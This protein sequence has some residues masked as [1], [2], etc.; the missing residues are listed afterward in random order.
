MSERIRLYKKAKR[1]GALEFTNKRYPFGSAKFWRRKGNEAIRARIARRVRKV[2]NEP[3]ILKNIFEDDENFRKIKKIVKIK[4]KFDKDED[5][6]DFS[7]GMFFDMTPIKDDELFSG[8]IHISI[9]FIDKSQQGARRNR[10]KTFSG[11]KVR[12][13]N[14]VQIF[15]YVDAVIQDYFGNFGD[16]EGYTIIRGT[17]V[18]LIKPIPK[19]VGAIKKMKVKAVKF[20]K[21][22]LNIQSNN[23]VI[24]DGENC[25]VHYIK[26]RYGEQKGFIKKVKNING[27]QNWTVEQCIKFLEDCNIPY[28][29]YLGDLKLFKYKL[30]RKSKAKI[31]RFIF[32]N[33]HIYPV[34]KKELNGLKKIKRDSYKIKQI[35]FKENLT[36]YI[37]NKMADGKVIKQYNIKYQDQKFIFERALI[38]ETLYVDDIDLVNSH[39]L[40]T[41]IMGFFPIS[42]N[43]KIY[44]PLIYIC[45][46]EKIFS[47]FNFDMEMNE[48]P[49][50]YNPDSMK[51][52]NLLCI[53]K[54]KCYSYM[55][56]SLKYI[57]VLNSQCFP[58]KYNEDE[59]FNEDYIYH[60]KKITKDS[61][62]FLSAG[63]MS[64]HR[65]K[66]FLDSVE[67]D[68]VIKPKLI[69]N[70]FSE[71]IEKMFQT[72][73]KL[74]KFII[75]VFYGICRISQYQDYTCH[76]RLVTSI[77]E[78][79]E[80]GDFRKI[81]ND[82]FQLY[83]LLE[84]KEHRLK[85]KFNLM[86]I[87]MFILDKAVNTLVEKI[88]ECKKLDPNLKVAKIKT[89]AFTMITD[90]IKYED[91]D[92]DKND[93][94]KW[95]IEPIGK[96]REQFICT[97]TLDEHE[98][99]TELDKNT[100]IDESDFILKSNAYTLPQVID[101]KDVRKYLDKNI[102]FDCLAG[103]G[104]TYECL[105]EIIPLLK[106]QNKKWLVISSQHCS[107]E[108]YYLKNHNAKV[109]QYYTFNSKVHVEFSTYDTIIIDEF[110]KLEPNQIEFIFKNCGKHCNLIFL[111]D[112]GQLLPYGYDKN[113][114]SPV[115][116]MELYKLFDYVVKLEDNWR[117]KYTKNQYQKM[118][119]L[120][121]KLTDYERK[122][123]DRI[124]DLNITVTRRTMDKINQK[125][126]KDW[127]DEFTF[128]DKKFK[129]KK[130][131]KII[132]EFFN[133]KN[134]NKLHKL[135][136]YNGI[137][138]TIKEYDKDNITI[139]DKYNKE[140]IIPMD[141]FIENFNYGYAI[142]TFRAQGRS[143]DYDKMGV[144]DYFLIRKSGRTLYTVF[145][146]IKN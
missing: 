97:D 38:D 83:T 45:E 142:T 108:E 32:T 43:Y 16:G 115:E 131:G 67:I 18:K 37:V 123:I 15:E 14:K 127:K 84:H 66:N 42:F 34:E 69:L 9:R 139:I 1:N 124:S 98:Y 57:P 111:G 130:D 8:T 30:D 65:I 107:L 17:S 93:I 125:K 51:K 114:P 144:H 7:F 21:I 135:G 95:K 99:I 24:P 22:D 87:S 73:S 134:F 117:N 27:E 39:K 132:S 5:E 126:I 13:L 25:F 143:I 82:H 106:D 101:K 136:I 29:A 76:K 20:F 79:K 140:Y 56:K 86:P 52:K 80:F 49:Y 28:Y 121:F 113:K 110:G 103:S 46:K 33:E 85:Y 58:E 2:R 10:T 61:R 71:L 137:F 72:N 4:K 90:V 92:L 36:N 118:K 55:L 96:R 53:D 40:F 3:R 91:L 89:D 102:L 70:P 112:K 23:D 41:Q 138:Y 94:S 141:L 129:L 128:G 47:S 78:A 75:N 105:N 59:P 120:K 68:Y 11:T 19:R 44:T 6:D 104:K 35:K 50:Y 133:R 109:I 119:D 145:S 12:N 116:N 48:A 54:N 64:G 100:K 77:D 88:D 31:F 60:V 63:K 146:R 74:S 122:L 26:T 62:C 81:Q